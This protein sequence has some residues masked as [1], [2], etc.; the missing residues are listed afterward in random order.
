MI[1]RGK[2]KH[3]NIMLIYGK[4]KVYIKLKGYD[5]ICRGNMKNK[6]IYSNIFLL[7]SI[8]L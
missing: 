7:F 5:E 6:K 2:G 1:E 8:D 4:D 3:V